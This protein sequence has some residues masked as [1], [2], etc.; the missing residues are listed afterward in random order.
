M[1]R[2]DARI[3]VFLA[4]AADAALEGVFWLVEDAAAP[5]AGEAGHAPGCACCVA[6]SPVAEM[7][8]RLFRARAVGEVPYF[9]RLGAVPAGPVGG[10]ALRAALESDNFV[11]FCFRL[12]D[13]T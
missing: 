2:T 13:E 5:W 3:A 7:L 4:E 6:R 8:G 1:V 9:T 11:S 12:C 10:A